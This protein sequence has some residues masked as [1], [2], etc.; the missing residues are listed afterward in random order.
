MSFAELKY[1]GKENNI[2]GKNGC[3][4]RREKVDNIS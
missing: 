2:V 4:G 1:G 3:G